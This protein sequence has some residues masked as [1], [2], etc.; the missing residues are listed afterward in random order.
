MALIARL[1]YVV[2]RAREG[3]VVV[4]VVQEPRSV[5]RYS[6]ARAR[7]YKPPKAALPGTFT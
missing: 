5:L 3:M 7:A 2:G 1:L 4:T 6:A